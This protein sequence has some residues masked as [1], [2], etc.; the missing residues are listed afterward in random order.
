MKK[1]KKPVALPESSMPAALHAAPVSARPTAM[2]DAPRPWWRRTYWLCAGVGLATH[3]GIL[4]YARNAP[5]PTYD[6]GGGDGTYV[7]IESDDTPEQNKP[8][9]AEIP[10]PTDDST[11]STASPNSEE[12]AGS[13][14]PNNRPRGNVGPNY[15]TDPVIGTNDPNASNASGSAPDAQRPRWDP[16]MDDNAYGDPG[17]PDSRTF[18]PLNPIVKGGPVGF[19]P[20]S[21]G[22][23]P[24]A[25]TT[26]EKTARVDVDKANQV[27]QEQLHEKDKKLGLILP[28][29]GTVASTV[30][31]AV[32]SSSVPEKSQGTIVV[33]LGPDGK[34]TGVKV[35]GMAGGTAGDWEAI[36]ANVRAALS[37]KTLNLTDEYKKG[38]IITI[39]VRSKM[40]NPSGSD[41]DNPVQLGTTTKFDLSDIGAKPIRQVTTQT[42]VVAVK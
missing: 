26:T 24:A 3:I 6:F 30:K 9:S 41:P 35:A 27:L 31:D 21:I 34:V 33:S 25:K 1:P 18:D 32:W 20:S 19:D 10:K 39:N 29:A 42:N 7:D 11:A 40:Q 14:V 2:M 15:G 28:A 8:T 38:A 13:V 12:T 5:T 36:A 16:A 37:A 4:A 23:G 22:T 17:A